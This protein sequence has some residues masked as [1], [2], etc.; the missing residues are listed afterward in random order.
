MSTELMRVHVRQAIIKQECHME[1]MIANYTLDL[2]E[3]MKALL[4]SVI[5]SWY[6]LRTD[7]WNPLPIAHNVTEISRIVSASRS[8]ASVILSR[9][10]DEGLVRRAAAASSC[11][12]SSLRIPKRGSL[13]PDGLVRRCLPCFLRALQGFERG[14]APRVDAPAECIGVGPDRER[15]I[16]DAAD[17]ADADTCGVETGDG[18][19]VPVEHVQALVDRNARA[20]GIVFGLKLERIVVRALDGSHPVGG[21]AELIV[22]AFGGGLV[23]GEDGALQLIARDAHLH[24]ELG[25]I[26]CGHETAASR[27]GGLLEFGPQLLHLQRLHG[28]AREAARG[29]SEQNLIHGGVVPDGPD[30]TAVGG[31]REDACDARIPED[32]GLVHDAGPLGADPD[33]VRLSGHVDDGLLQVHAERARRLASHEYGHDALGASLSGGQRGRRARRRPWVRFSDS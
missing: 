12:D 29:A 31:L 17:A 20:C 25:E 18:P 19:V 9:W 4:R 24:G 33:V 23:V 5:E 3:R 7:G 22:E 11:T 1:G 6:P 13:L 28:D 16:G 27:S 21:L 15:A 2:A 10:T 30:G 26:A 14:L 32:L 8:S